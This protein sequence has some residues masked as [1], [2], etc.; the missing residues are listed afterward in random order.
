MRVTVDGPDGWARGWISTGARAP[1]PL[2][3]SKVETC[4]VS[5]WMPVWAGWRYLVSCRSQEHIAHIPCWP[6]VSVSVT[7]EQ[8]QTD[9]SRWRRWHSLNGEEEWWN[10]GMV[11]WRDGGGGGGVRL[12][13]KLKFPISKIRSSLLTGSEATIAAKES[14]AAYRLSGWGLI[15]K[16]AD[17]GACNNGELLPPHL[18]VTE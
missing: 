8:G 11:E 3:D 16:I 9:G 10:G 7:E 4:T 18:Q 6:A 2:S 1:V 5:A 14:L 13:K 12:I 15:L 17:R